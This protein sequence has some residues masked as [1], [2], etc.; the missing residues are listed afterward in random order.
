MFNLD[1]LLALPQQ[2]PD[3]PTDPEP[4][5]GRTIAQL[6][7]DIVQKRDYWPFR[8]FR[9]RNN[10]LLEPLADALRVW[11]DA[12]STPLGALETLTRDARP[13][14]YPLTRDATKGLDRVALLGS[15]YT[16]DP[17]QPF[18]AA[19]E[20]RADSAGDLRDVDVWDWTGSQGQQALR[21][22]LQA[23]YLEC[24]DP[25]A[26]VRL[27]TAGPA[28]AILFLPNYVQAQIGSRAVQRLKSIAASY[29]VLLHI[30]ADLNTANNL[31]RAE[32]GRKVELVVSWAR[33]ERV[34]DIRRFNDGNDQP[35]HTMRLES[36]DVEASVEELGRRMEDLL[37]AW[38]TAR[39]HR[40]ILNDD[41][42]YY[43]Q[44]KG[45]GG[46]RDEF[47]PRRN[48]CS[49]NAWGGTDRAPQAQNGA[50][51]F[52]GEDPSGLER[53]TNPSCHVYRARLG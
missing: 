3:R 25:D 49:H 16:G 22:R 32:S 46:G 38:P 50:A 47:D 27:P 23:L 4:T 29:S 41:G 15:F 12:G 35:E 19:L 34:E 8:L 6:R 48:P 28:A 10:Q 17:A 20:W 2:V 14:I 39:R 5:V 7:N 21:T 11:H 51:D 36:F 26:M 40:G 44:K 9:R 37:T 13:F 42:W 1:W 53:C 52:F 18:V 45:G 33:F 30:P 24:R 43:L 31:T